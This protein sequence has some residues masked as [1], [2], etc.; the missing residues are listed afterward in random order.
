MRR[1]CHMLGIASDLVK[2][3]YTMHELRPHIRRAYHALATRYHPDHSVQQRQ[4]L[5]TRGRGYS[6]IYNNQGRMF[7]R[8]THI[9][10]WL[11]AIPAD[12]LLHWRPVPVHEL[13]AWLET[14][15]P[16]GALPGI[17]E[18]NTTPLGEGWQEVRGWR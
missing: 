14:L 16:Q 18:R 8:L 6:S 15:G 17:I 4:A 9:Y 5:E 7:C 11:M 3:C 2:A 10:S 1:R 12:A 13:R